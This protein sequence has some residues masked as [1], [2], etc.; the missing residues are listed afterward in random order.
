MFRNYKWRPFFSAQVNR[1]HDRRKNQNGRRPKHGKARTRE[2]IWKSV[3][4]SDLYFLYFRLYINGDY[5][6]Q[7]SVIWEKL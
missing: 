6:I 3:V 4:I 1:E 7:N 5:E 2:R